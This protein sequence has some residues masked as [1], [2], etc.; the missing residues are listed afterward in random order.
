MMI[1][2]ATC[3]T[4]LGV[5]SDFG[6]LVIKDKQKD[7]DTYHFVIQ[8]HSMKQFIQDKCTILPQQDNKPY[9]IINCCQCG[10]DI[11]KI[12]ITIKMYVCVLSLTN[13]MIYM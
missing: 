8:P 7:I 9:E 11:G 10:N 12:F 3:A 1:S 4:E 2:C 13:T 6:F 5:P